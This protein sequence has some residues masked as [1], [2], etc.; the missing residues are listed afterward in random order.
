MMTPE[1]QYAHVHRLLALR[2][3]EHGDA[4]LIVVA[5]ILAG[6]TGAVARSYV[7]EKLAAVRGAYP[8]NLLD[9]FALTRLQMA[10]EEHASNPIRWLGSLT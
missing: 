9:P 7:F 6:R 5:A 10:L 2:N 1:L 8:E 3:E 4:E